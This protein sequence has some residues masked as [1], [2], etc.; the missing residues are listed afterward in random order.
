MLVL[1]FGMLALAAACTEKKTQSS[2]EP[3]A[4]P[5][6]PPPPPPAPLLEKR[7]AAGETAPR[8]A[9]ADRKLTQ[10]EIKW[11]ETK[12]KRAEEA[13]LAKQLADE[14]LARLKKFDK[15]KLAKH[16]ALLAFEKKTRKQLEDAAAKWKGKPDA[17]DQ[18]VKL[19][20]ALRKG[21][22]AQATVLKSIDPEARG[23]SNIATDH[24]VSLNLLANDYPDAIALSFKGDEKPLADV[25]SEMDKRE[26]KIADWLDEL[27]KK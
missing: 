13:A 17:Q 18:I 5:T 4:R 14:E 23:L 1:A 19:A 16:K 6:P 12:R 11:E 8:D 10:M 2:V 27:K 25:R 3:A 7:P 15:T 22:E 20:A 21:I 24:D 9:A 26:K